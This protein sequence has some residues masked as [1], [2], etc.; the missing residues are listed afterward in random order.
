[1]KLTSLI[2]GAIALAGLSAPALADGMPAKKSV[3]DTHVAP[4]AATWTGFYAGA[5]VGLV[6]DKIDWN[7]ESLFGNASSPGDLQTNST[8]FNSTGFKYGLYAGYNKQF[9][10]IV[11][12]VEADINGKTGNQK[13]VSYIPGAAFG[14]TGVGDKT[15]VDSDFDGSIR[16]RAGVLVMPTTLLYV[17]GGYAF[18]KVNTT[19]LCVGATSPWCVANREEFKSK[20]LNGWTIGGGAETLL[21]NN[22]IARLDYRYSDYGSVKHS[23]FANAPIDQVNAKIGDK[24]H[25]VML[26]IGYKF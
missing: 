6:W 15:S 7:T 21:S 9:D 18:D 24:T 25:S 22:I 3:K 13:D 4:V 8:H 19:M 1:M 23:Y 16:L 14:T 26:G 20:W 17:T 5:A 10:R 2:V 11:L 12:G